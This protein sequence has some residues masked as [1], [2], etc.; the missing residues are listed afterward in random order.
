MGV[1]RH[2]DWKE[3]PGT[4]LATVQREW[5]IELNRYPT[6]PSAAVA[7]ERPS[8][9]PASEAALGGH[10]Q[11]TTGHVLRTPAPRCTPAGGDA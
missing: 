1:V 4:N 9:R 6:C 10:T 8:H 7:L 11:L 5:V 3:A 2:P